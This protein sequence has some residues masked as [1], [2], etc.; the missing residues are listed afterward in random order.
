MESIHE[1]SLNFNFNFLNLVFL[2]FF[3]IFQLFE[4][5]MAS[6]NNSINADPVEH[7]TNLTPT[8]SAHHISYLCDF[9]VSIFV[10]NCFF[11]RSSKNLRHL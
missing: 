5:H 9:P 8:S 4:R 1:K 11:T 10:Y 2:I 6:L 7:I 3:L